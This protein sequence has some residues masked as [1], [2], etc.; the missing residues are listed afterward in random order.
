MNLRQLSIRDPAVQD[1]LWQHLTPSDFREDYTKLDC[2]KRI[3]ESC[4][5]DNCRLYGDMEV[6]FMFRC[7]IRNSKVLE[8]HVMG[9]GRYFRSAIE[10]GAPMA[11]AMGFERIVIWTHHK[12]IARLAHKVGF[13]LDAVIPK[14]HIVNGVLRDVYALGMDKPCDILLS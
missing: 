2:I 10:Q 4:Y 6:G 8:P 3:E 7:T 12:Q 9:N 1:F 11:W 13:E 14:Q 5:Q